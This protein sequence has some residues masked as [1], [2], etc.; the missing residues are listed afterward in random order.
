VSKKLNDYRKDVKEVG[1]EIPFTL[2]TFFKWILGVMVVLA[3][4]GFIAQSLGIISLNIEREKVQHSQ[5][6]TETKVTLLEKLHSDWFQL[7][8]E[9]TELKS[10]EGNEEIIDAKKAQQKSIVK[11][12]KTE[13]SRIPNSQIPDEIKTFIL[14]H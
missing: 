6:Y 10:G 9:I 1:K 12:I 13:A 8:S 14:T 4:L 11:R 2:W 7:N 3:V 5:Q